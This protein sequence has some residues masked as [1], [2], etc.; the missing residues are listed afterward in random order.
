M[1]RGLE[2]RKLGEQLRARVADLE[3]ANRTINELNEGLQDRVAHAT[4]ELELGEAEYM[5][6]ARGYVKFDGEWMTPAEAQIAQT[7]LAASF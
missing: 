6:R 7:N 3:A 2:R 1:A 4:A 5:V